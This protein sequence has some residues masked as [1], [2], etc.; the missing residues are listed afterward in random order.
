MIFLDFHTANEKKIESKLWEAHGKVNARF[1]SQLAKFKDGEDKKKPVEKRKTEKLYLDFI[2]SSQRFYRGYIQRLASHFSGVP[3][4]LQ[5]AHEFKLESKIVEYLVIAWLT[6][7]ALSADKP[8]QA[9]EKLHSQILISCHSTLIHL[10]DLSRYRETELQSKERNWGP[11]KGYY[12]L[13]MTLD[14]SS[15]ASYNQLAVIALAD[16]NHFN[17]IYYLYRAISVKNPFPTSRANLE[18]DFKKVIDR[19]KKNALLPPQLQRKPGDVL[20]AHFVFYHASCYSGVDFK[21]RSELENEILTH[22][23]VDLKEYSL[24]GIV[25]RLTLINIAADHLARQKFISE[26]SAPPQIDYQQDDSYDER[27]EIQLKLLFKMISAEQKSPD[28]TPLKFFL[29][30]NIKTFFALLQI[31]S[32]EL[33][34]DEGLTP[35]ACRILPSLRHYS[36]WLICSYEL[37]LTIRDENM[38]VQIQELWKRYAEVL[39]LMASFRPVA[40][41][42]VVEYLL[43]EDLKTLAFTPFLNERA[44]PRHQTNGRIKPKMDDVLVNRL[45]Q[46]DEMLARIRDFL[47]DS[48]QVVRIPVSDSRD[49]AIAILIDPFRVRKKASGLRFIYEAVLLYTKHQDSSLDQHQHLMYQICIPIPN[50]LRA[51]RG[52]T[53]SKQNCKTIRRNR[54]SMT[55]KTFPK[56]QRLLLPSAPRCTRW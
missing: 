45:S 30:F 48:L 21:Q 9:D 5:V 31:L 19:H 33:S 11:A 22:L 41:M 14:P 24:D 1:R 52:K 43:E 8:V 56:Q 28:P 36:S 16:E 51:L 40:D 32:P 23:A 13:A 7:A 35:T 54:I 39:T 12:D 53:S 25:N 55:E 4:V 29:T 34:T 26:C 3:E 27:A 20:K 2:K 37:L 42:P 44:S 18:L 46:N 38:I 15:G 17:A 47:S 49:G 6:I 10:G 50:L